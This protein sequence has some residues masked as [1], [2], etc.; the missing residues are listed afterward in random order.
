MIIW[1]NTCIA[2]FTGISRIKKIFYGSVT[3]LHILDIDK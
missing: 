1:E 2:S 3:Q